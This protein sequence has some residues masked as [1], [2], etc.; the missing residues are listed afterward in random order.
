MKLQF[1]KNKPNTQT[2]QFRIDPAT[3]QKLTALRNFHGVRTGELL[4]EMINIHY[5]E[6]VNEKIKERKV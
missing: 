6:M 3:H 5:D 1:K 2:V 4:K